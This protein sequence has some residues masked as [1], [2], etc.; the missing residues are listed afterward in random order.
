LQ[1]K[2]IEWVMQMNE[3]KVQKNGE[4]ERRTKRRFQIATQY[5][6]G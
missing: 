4:R 3:P 1:G 2:A 5:V 6:F